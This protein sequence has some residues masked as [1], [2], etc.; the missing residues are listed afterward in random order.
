MKS[1]DVFMKCGHSANAVLKT[2]E[3]VCVICL[4]IKSGAT[5]VAETPTLGGRASREDGNLQGE[6]HD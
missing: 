5:I 3:P 1:C 4:G 6:V 2:G